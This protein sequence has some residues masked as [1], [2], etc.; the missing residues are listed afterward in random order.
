MTHATE[1]AFRREDQ[2]PANSEA[3]HPKVRNHSGEGH[4]ASNLVMFIFCMILLVASFY[5]FGLWISDSKAWLPF[6]IAIVL[7]GLTFLVPFQLLSSKT[8]KHSTSGKDITQ[9]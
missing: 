9:L 2:K 1:S 6:A 4:L 8:A 7:Y 3:S 5:C